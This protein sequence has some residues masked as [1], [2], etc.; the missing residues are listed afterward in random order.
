MKCLN[1]NN[2]TKHA[3]KFQSWYEDQLCRFCAYELMPQK[4]A[5]PINTQKMPQYGKVSSR[6]RR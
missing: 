3:P 5:I 2:K 4:Y 6:G 1:C